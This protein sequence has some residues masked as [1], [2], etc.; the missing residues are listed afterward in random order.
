MRRQSSRSP[1]R[2]M[3]VALLFLVAS[4]CIPRQVILDDLKTVDTN[5]PPA[6]SASDGF[7]ANS[8]AQD[9][10]YPVHATIYDKQVFERIERLSHSAPLKS[11]L[12]YETMQDV[13]EDP[14]LSQELRGP[15]VRG[16][17]YLG[18]H[19]GAPRFIQLGCAHEASVS[20]VAIRQA[21][22]LDQVSQLCHAL[23]DKAYEIGGGPC[24][25]LQHVALGSFR[26]LE[27][28]ARE[29]AKQQLA[30]AMMREQ[31]RCRFELQATP[32]EPF[33]PGSPDGF[34][35][36][37]ISQLLSPTTPLA[38]M[39]DLDQ[40]GFQPCVFINDSFLRTHEVLSGSELSLAR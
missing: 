22:H 23:Y 30:R 37:V 8:G 29:E 39:G 1:M 25:S 10:T 20:H 14:E 7:L 9:R 38:W 27:R 26:L 13:M 17:V 31:G 18:I 5:P 33:A 16:L 28:Q 6:W 40:G 15:M 3:M 32:V 21:N 2:A 24:A 35:T 19:E 4:A 36:V 11:D 12:G 34:I